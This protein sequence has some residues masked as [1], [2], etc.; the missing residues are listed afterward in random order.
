[1]IVAWLSRDAWR[2]M[3]AE[4]DRKHP[5]ETGGVL[6]GYWANVGELV[7]RA[8]SG[9]GDKAVHERHRFAPDYDCQEGWIAE[10][11]RLSGGVDTYLGDWHTHPDAP[12][13][14]PSA[15]DRRT[16]RR[17]AAHDEA[18]APSPLLIILAGDPRR[19]SAF[20]WVA[21]LKWVLGIYQQVRL[22]PCKVRLF[23]S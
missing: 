9:P 10:R 12:V 17:I 2:T 21:T 4:A 23:D 13:A 3:V 6:A 8:A 11:Y 14:V 20:C 18:R 1:M 22:N 5:L 16:A 7:I 19:W 15:A